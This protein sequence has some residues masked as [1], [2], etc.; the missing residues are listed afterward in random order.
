MRRAGETRCR[1]AV[2]MV[3]NGR[4]KVSVWAGLSAAVVA[5]SVWAEPGWA[6]AT[7]GGVCWER[8]E[9]EEPKGLDADLTGAFLSA[10][11]AKAQPV[12][13]GQGEA[14]GVAEEPE[15]EEGVV[16]TP[17]SPRYGSAGS[18]WLTIGGGVANNFHNDTDLNIHGAWSRFLADEVEFSMEVGG[19][20]FAQE[21]DDTAGI[22]W[23]VIFR[24]HAFHD[25]AFTWTVYF[26]AGIGVLG[27]FDNVP[28]DGTGF[29]FTPRLGAGFTH[30]IGDEGTRLQIGVRWHHISN[31][32][33]EG[34]ERNPGR[35]SVMV[36]AGVIFPF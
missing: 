31:G 21:G 22:N 11:A 8:G 3:K 27:S 28:G 30:A 10:A 18:E 35:D 33:I 2:G 6:G 23:N 12:T 1:Y 14:A 19:W 7:G 15:E 20:Y 32:R 26:D 25:E 4:V 5:L 9:A 24:W 16:V 36:Y 29:N 13:E 34:D 17:I